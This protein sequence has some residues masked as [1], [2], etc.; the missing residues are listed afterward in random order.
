MGDSLCQKTTEEKTSDLFF[1]LDVGEEEGEI[2]SPLDGLLPPLGGIV[3][4]GQG[5]V[6]DSM[7]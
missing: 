6:Y 2:S 7:D 3:A 1:S 4:S 5:W